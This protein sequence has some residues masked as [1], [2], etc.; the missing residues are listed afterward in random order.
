[1]IK[2]TAPLSKAQMTLKNNHTL[3]ISWLE[4]QI[5]KGNNSI[6]L[7]SKNATVAYTKLVNKYTGLIPDDEV[8]YFMASRL[9]DSVMK[10]LL[11]TLRVAETRNKSDF[12]LQVTITNRN[13]ANLEK[14]ASQTGM[15]RNEIINKLLELA[16]V[17]KISKSEE[18]LEITL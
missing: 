7:N 16:T 6:F 1:M 13:R 17:S 9:T 15:K 5:A 14:L 11:T 12:T 4:N 10:K 3:Q 8:E 2:R 18:Q